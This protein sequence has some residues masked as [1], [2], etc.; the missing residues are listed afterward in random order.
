MSGDRTMKTA[1][2]SDFIGVINI[3]VKF[4]SHEY[5]THSP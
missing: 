5:L 2:L 3:R 4:N 1:V